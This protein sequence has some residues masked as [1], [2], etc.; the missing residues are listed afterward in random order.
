MVFGY[1]STRTLSKWNKEWVNKLAFL[2]PALLVTVHLHLSWC[3]IN[4]LFPSLT[5]KIIPPTFTRKLK[6]CNTVV[7][8]A[9]EMEC[10]VSG[11]PPFTISWYHDEE[12]IQSGPNY[13]IS[14]SDNSCMLKVPTLKLS[15]SGAYK[16]KAVNKAGSSETT[17]S[18]VVKGQELQPACRFRSLIQWIHVDFS[19]A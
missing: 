18:F 13:E 19:F 17:A 2:Y 6:D 12:E 3:T 11:S 14:F 16:C 8:N 10:K 7:G 9:G 5:D 15:D 1:I 4:F